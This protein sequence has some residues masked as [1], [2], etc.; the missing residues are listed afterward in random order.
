MNFL[1]CP[2]YVVLCL[3]PGPPIVRG[4]AKQS[5]YNMDNVADGNSVRSPSSYLGG[6]RVLRD[7]TLRH[8]RAPPNQ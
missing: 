1:I 3:E 5:Q 6:I 2:G 4:E 8:Q 7:P